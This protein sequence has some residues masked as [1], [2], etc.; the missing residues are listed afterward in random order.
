VDLVSAEADESL[1]LSAL[2]P[3]TKSAAAA[4]PP[5]HPLAYI[6]LHTDPDPEFS[7]VGK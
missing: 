7:K 5:N 1:V 2:Q 6:A 3:T 4:I